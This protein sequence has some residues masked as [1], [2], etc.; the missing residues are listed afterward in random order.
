MKAIEDK[1]GFDPNGPSETMNAIRNITSVG[2]VQEA[3]DQAEAD[4]RAEFG[5]NR[6]GDATDAFRHADL[7]IRMVDAV[8]ADTAKSFADAHERGTGADRGDRLQDLINNHNARILRGIFPD[9]SPR[10]LA[11]AALSNGLL[12]RTYVNQGTAGRT[13]Y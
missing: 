10:D 5:A 11:R 13:K 4:T 12:Q 2:S 6:A 9:A 8:G 1:V 3:G 7:N